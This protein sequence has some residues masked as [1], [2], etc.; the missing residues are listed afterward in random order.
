MVG[1]HDGI[2]LGDRVSGGNLVS[3]MSHWSTPGSAGKT[4]CACDMP[5][6]AGQNLSP[7]S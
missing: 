2:E 3:G 7:M 1:I 5:R 6:I 4:K